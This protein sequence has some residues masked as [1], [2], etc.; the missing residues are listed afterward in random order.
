MLRLRAL[1]VHKIDPLRAPVHNMALLSAIWAVGRSVVLTPGHVNK[2]CIQYVCPGVW[3]TVMAVTIY[4]YN[5]KKTDIYIY[6]YIYIFID[7]TS[8]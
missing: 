2:P 8:G 7:I 4:V 6:A 3:A 5:Y 1:V